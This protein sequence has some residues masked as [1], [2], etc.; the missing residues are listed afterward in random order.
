MIALLIVCMPIAVQAKPIPMIWREYLGRY[1]K[2]SWV[3]T[4]VLYDPPGDGSYSEF[5][6]AQTITSMIKYGGAYVGFEASGQTTQ[7]WTVTTDCSTPSSERMSG[8][9]AITLNQVWDLWEYDYPSRVVYKAILVSSTPTGGKMIWRFDELATQ[10]LWV[11]DRTGTQGAYSAPRAVGAN[12]TMSETFEYYC[13]NINV[14]GAGYFLN[15]VGF[16][17]K[18]YI[19]SQSVSSTKAEVSYTYHDSS[20]NLVFN[21]ES[22]YDINWVHSQPY[23]VDGISIWFD[24]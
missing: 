3:P 1:T 16:N 6:E 20:A 2:L 22:N 17:F 19:E 12:M 13:S 5:T 18:I 7:I 23:Y 9:V 11:T 15:L 21:I 4:F 24:Q 10:N 8:V 14:Y